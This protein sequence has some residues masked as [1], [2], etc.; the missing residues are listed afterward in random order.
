M[1]MTIYLDDEYVL[2]KLEQL[3]NKYEVSYLVSE[4]EE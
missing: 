3:L 1:K 4:V 2:F